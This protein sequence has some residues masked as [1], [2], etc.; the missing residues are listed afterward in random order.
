MSLASSAASSVPVRIGFSVSEKLSVSIA[1]GDTPERYKSA[2]GA[3]RS[4][5]HRSWAVN[6]TPRLIDRGGPE[7]TRNITLLYRELH[8][9]SS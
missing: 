8:L 9:P 5:A 4:A 2:S 3:I 7:H 1:L 6:S